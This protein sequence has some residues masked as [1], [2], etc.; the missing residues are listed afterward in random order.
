MI[1]YNRETKRQYP[2]EDGMRTPLP[3]GS[4]VLY[5]SFRA[6][7]A[8]QFG[9]DYISK[10]KTEWK[11]PF[12]LSTGQFYNLEMLMKAGMTEKECLIEVRPAKEKFEVD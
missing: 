4:Y 1:A 9:D 6:H 2:L 8:K 5:A 11:K 12:T 10:A 7:C 3:A